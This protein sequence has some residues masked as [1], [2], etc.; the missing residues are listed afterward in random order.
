LPISAG[1]TK[2]L[3][4][5]ANL[6][7]L[8]SDYDGPS[9]VSVST[10]PVLTG[11]DSNSNVV[12]AEG[13]TVTGNT[14][15]IY[16][17]APTFAYVN[18]S[19]TVSGSSENN[20]SDIADTAITF[21]VTANGSDIYIATK[22]TTDT[23]LQGTLAG[24]SSAVAATGQI[25]FTATPTADG[26]ATTTING[27]SV[28]YSYSTTTPD[29]AETVANEL[30]AAI[31]ADGTLSALVSAATTTDDDGIINL[32][33]VT[34]GYDGNSITYNATTTAATGITADPSTATNMTGGLNTQST[35]TTWTCASP[36]DNNTAGYW[37]IPEGL[38]ANCTFSTL[39][40][41]T[42]ATANYFSVALSNVT[43]ATTAT[44]TTV[45]DQ[46]WG[47]T[48]IKTSDFALGI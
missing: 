19:V 8:P 36:A 14:Q 5:K 39:V 3:T 38:T 11:I 18:S 31:N 32:T 46:T 43:W 20:T 21:S 22:D 6:I 10:G 29:Y 41:N 17:E 44:T 16:I 25:V 4:L 26:V 47:L 40:T 23:A 13:A 35:S 28:N 48:N 2:T 42:N 12:S 27:T 7:Q 37:K 33:A 24:G 45:V 9:T 30:A 1:T 15:H 34:A